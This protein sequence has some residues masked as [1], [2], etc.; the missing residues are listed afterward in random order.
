MI[1]LGITVVA[2]VAF[3]ALRKYTSSVDPMKEP[4]IGTLKAVSFVAL[5][6][7][8][9]VPLGV[10]FY[11]TFRTIPAGNVGV[12]TLFGAVRPTPLPEGFNIT[13]PLV[14]VTNLSIQIQKHEAN[15]LAA[16]KDMQVV[17]VDMVLNFR[18]RAEKAPEVF[19][20]V[21]QEY[22]RVI[23]DPAAQE[24][25]KAEVAQHNAIEILGARPK[26]KDEIQKRLSVWLDKYGIELCEA[27]IANVK[28]DPAY[29]KAI[30]TKQVKEQEAEQKKYELIQAQK[31]AEIAEAKAKGLA[32]SAMAKARGDAEATKIRADAEAEFNRKVSQS[33]TPEILKNRFFEKWNGELPRVLSGGK[34]NL[35]FAVDTPS[36]KVEEKK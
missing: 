18:L 32:N 2:L 11:S 23:I 34:E 6:V 14:E 13:M 33:L 22:P 31:E 24:V 19:Q 10:G 12:S 21:G 17:H 1:T 29:E 26:V 27:S 8:I 16:S 7:A 36:A 25:V 15:Y 9:L 20:K 30:E 5:A 3:L 4:D 35:L 28:F